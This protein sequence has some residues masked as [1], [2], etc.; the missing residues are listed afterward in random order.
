VNSA[1]RVEVMRL[2]GQREQASSI[3]D[4][5]DPGPDVFNEWK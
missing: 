5:N 1:L 4:F 2:N 3:S